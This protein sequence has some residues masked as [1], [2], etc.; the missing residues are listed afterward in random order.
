M[1]ARSVHTRG[2]CTSS[3]F[4][5]RLRYD[6]GT[7]ICS[8]EVAVDRGGDGGQRER[9]IGFGRGDAAASAHK[10]KTPRGPADPESGTVQAQLPEGVIASQMRH[11]WSSRS[12]IWVWAIEGTRSDADVGQDEYYLY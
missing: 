5:M 8:E 4:F 3:H 10:C 11:V 6:N 9:G 12:A 2:A 1:G 7:D